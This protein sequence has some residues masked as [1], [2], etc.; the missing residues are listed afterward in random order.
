[1][2]FPME[3]EILHQLQHWKNNLNRKPLILKGVRQVGKTYV[4]NEFG[5][6]T[7]KIS[8]YFNFEKEPKLAQIFEQDLNPVRILQ[9]LSLQRQ[10]KIDYQN[11]LIIFDEIQ[12][13]PQA[14]T[15][16]KYF[17][18]NMPPGC[19]CCAGSLLGVYLGPVSYPV[20]KVEHLEMHPMSFIEFL[21]AIG[22]EM[23]VALLNSL[24]TTS[25]IPILA[26]EHLWERLKHYFIVGGLPEPVSLYVKHKNDLFTAFQKVRALQRNLLE[27]YFSDIA[28]HSGKLNAIHIHRIWQSVPEQLGLSQDGSARKFKFKNITPGI[29]RFA[30]LSNA[31]DWLETAG[32]IIKVYIAHQGLLPLRSYVQENT[33]KLFMFDVGILGAMSDLAP[34]TILQYNYGSFKGYFAENYVAQAF[35]AGQSG[36]LFSWSENSSEVEFLRQVE[37]NLI[38]VEVKSGWVTQ[39]KSLRVYAEK[40]KPPYRVIMSGKK[41]TIDNQAGVH[42][43]PLYLASQFPMT[44]TTT[45]K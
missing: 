43:Y 23:Y 29:D 7:F 32:L 39:A 14:L 41:L 2:I 9:D 3:R 17:C 28:K 42:N 20:G 24:S 40:Y 19:L 6:T 45:S 18:E 44:P 21:K 10:T 4:L 34:S 26:H 33:F 36:Q 5:A 1:M 13:C 31:I 38:P 27:D 11:D 37:G 25:V 15:S 8:H 12:A 30:K 22:D 16:L 35:I